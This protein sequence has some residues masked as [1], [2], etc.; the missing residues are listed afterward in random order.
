M[1]LL[2]AM[3]QPPGRKALPHLFLYNSDIASLAQDLS[4]FDA[5]L[6]ALM[7]L[8]DHLGLLEEPDFDPAW[9]VVAKPRKL[10]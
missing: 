2:E 1:T 3:S 10:K 9:G 4:A 6:C 7:A 5:F 8:A